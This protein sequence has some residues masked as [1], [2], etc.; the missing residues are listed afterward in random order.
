MNDYGH[1][2]LNT[3]IN[4]VFFSKVSLHSLGRMPVPDGE[5]HLVGFLIDGI[6]GI[7]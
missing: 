1:P 5:I 3:N 4:Q 6:A 7:S 2:S